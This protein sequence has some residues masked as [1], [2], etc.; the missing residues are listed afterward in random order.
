[1]KQALVF[2]IFCVSYT[3]PLEAQEA[4]HLVRK[5]LSE[6]YLYREGYEVNIE[7]ER[8]EVYVQPNLERKILIEV[9]VIARHPSEE[10]AK[11][12]VERMNSVIKR[13]QNKI[14]LRNYLETGTASEAQLKVIYRVTVPPECPVYIKNTYGITEVDRLSNSVKVNSKFSRISLQEVSGTIDLFTRYGDIHGQSLDGQVSI[15]SHR[16]DMLLQDINGAYDI[17][18]SYGNIQI[19]A[20]ADLLNLHLDAEKSQVMIFNP[21]AERFNYDLQTVHSPTI[22]PEGLEFQISQTDSEV[23]RLQY[24]PH[25]EFFPSFSVKVTFGT[26]QVQ[27]APRSK[28]P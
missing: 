1:M 12:D 22:L 3:T 27:R 23:Q 26:L 19:H 7:G 20:G 4:I 9:E 2:F 21:D 13:L 17:T 8:A 18:A 14:Y 11:I 5:T 25:Q 6:S 24:R 16:T 15:A 28:R 10:Q